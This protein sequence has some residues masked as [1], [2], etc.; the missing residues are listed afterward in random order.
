MLLNYPPS[1]SLATVETSAITCLITGFRVAGKVWQSQLNDI[2]VSRSTLNALCVRAREISS[3]QDTVT[4]LVQ[5]D[6]VRR[7]GCQ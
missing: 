3:V 1:G 6:Q 5:L 2:V 4:R 7:G